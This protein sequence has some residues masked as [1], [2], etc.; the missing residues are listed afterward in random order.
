MTDLGTLGGYDRSEGYGINNSGQVTG[1]S[2][3][4]GS[5]QISHGFLYSGGTMYDLND[6]I[7]HSS[8]WLLTEARGINADG[9]IVGTGSIG[10]EAH[11]FLLE[12]ES[13]EPATWA[14]LALGLATGLYLKRRRKT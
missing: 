13:P 12:Y 7:D 14:M 4:G 5:G 1:R 10:G 6:L 9:W 8:G 3:Q 11:G 2:D